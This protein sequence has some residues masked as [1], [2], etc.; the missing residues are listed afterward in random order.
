MLLRGPSRLASRSY[1][2]QC[3]RCRLEEKTLLCNA[4]KTVRARHT[5]CQHT[6]CQTFRNCNQLPYHHIRSREELSDS[7]GLPRAVYDLHLRLA[8]H[9]QQEQGRRRGG[10]AKATTEFAGALH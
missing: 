1:G 6:L 9:V 8:G 4:L 10:H 3:V 5:L 2:T 7:D